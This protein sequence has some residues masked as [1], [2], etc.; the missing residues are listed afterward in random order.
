M[1]VHTRKGTEFNWNWG[2][3]QGP[4][5]LAVLARDTSIRRDK[6]AFSGI[7]PALTVKCQER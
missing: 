2:S 5:F 7:F 4:S 1:G 6:L 3:W